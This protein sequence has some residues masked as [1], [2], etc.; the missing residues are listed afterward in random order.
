MWRRFAS[1]TSGASSTCW[2]VSTRALR[3]AR[4]SALLKPLDTPLHQR[5]S[6]WHALALEPLE[7][8]FVPTKARR[9]LQ[10]P[11]FVEAAGFPSAFGSCPSGSP[12]FTR[13][14]YRSREIKLLV[15]RVRSQAVKWSCV[16][17]FHRVGVT[18]RATPAL[19]RFAWRSKRDPSWRGAPR[20]IRPPGRLRS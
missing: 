13:R 11:R 5:P 17:E 3:A 8:R 15:Y 18:L 9:R 1:P 2:L 7:C 4:L 10:E 14:T 19:G 16:E 20:S 12:A 6:G